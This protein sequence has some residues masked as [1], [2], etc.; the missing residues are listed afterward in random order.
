MAKHIRLLQTDDEFDFA[1]AIEYVEPWLSYTEGK[2][3]D[4][5]KFDYSKIPFTIE[6]LGSGTIRWAL[7]EKVVQYSKNGGAWIEMDE[8]TR[9]SVVEGDV[10]QFKGDNPYYFYEDE[11]WDDDDDEYYTVKAEGTLSSTAR[12]NVKGNIMSLINSENFEAPSA[13]NESGYTFFGLFKN[14]TNLV[15]AKDLKL[16]T[17]TGYFCYHSMFRG[18]T[19]LIEP[20]ELPATTLSTYCYGCMF[21]GCTSLTIAPKLPATQLVN[22]CYTELFEG[23]T[24][25]RYINVMASGTYNSNGEYT[26]YWT[27]NVASGGIFVKNE[28]AVWNTSATSGIPTGWTVQTASH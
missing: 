25:L 5:N 28:N 14:N 21:L 12:F 27:R 3:I 8:T 15:S 4:Y 2:G 23:C 10:I 11:R 26:F 19:N 18:C 20:P 7:G 1:R 9:I 6:A 13:F 17:F 24:N 22:M 16:P